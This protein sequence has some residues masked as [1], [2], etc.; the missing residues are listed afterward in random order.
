MRKQCNS[1]EKVFTIYGTT[2]F[3]FN[4]LLWRQTKAFEASHD[5]KL[6]EAPKISI[7][8]NLRRCKNVNS[9]DLLAPTF[10]IINQKS[11]KSRNSCASLTPHRKHREIVKQHLGSC[12]WSEKKIFSWV[13]AVDHRSL[14]FFALLKFCAKEN[15]N[16]FCADRSCCWRRKKR[17]KKGKL[18]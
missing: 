10:V 16:Y 17:V 9:F 11:L 6:I 3:W 13:L 1:V 18:E 15:N 7:L 8:K 14:H 5:F 4:L 2:I 12:E